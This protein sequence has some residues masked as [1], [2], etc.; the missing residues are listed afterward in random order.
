[1]KKIIKVFFCILTCLIISIPQIYAEESKTKELSGAVEEKKDENVEESLDKEKKEVTEEPAEQSGLETIEKTAE[2]TSNETTELPKTESTSETEEKP[3]EEPEKE[4]SISYTTHIQD[5]GWQNQVK[6]GEMAGTEG[7]SKRL[8][9]IK[10]TLKDLSGVKIKYQTHIQD[11]GWQDWKYDG[12]LAGTE[13]QSKRLEAIRIELEESDKYSIMYRVH[14][15]D[16]G[17][18][19][20]RYDGEKAGTEGQSKRLEAI[21]IKIVEKQTSISV[22]YS[23]HVQDIG[24]QNWKA[25]EKIAGTE[26]QSKRLEAIKIE[27]LTNIK[28]LKLKYRVHIQDIGWQDW[29]DSEEM[30]GTEGQSKRLEAIQ[31]KLEN[32]QDYSIEY[33]VHV[34]DIG[35]QDWVKDGETSGTE[36]QSKRLEAIQIRIISKENDSN[37]QEEPKFERQ[38]GTYGKTG[39]NVADKG[40]SELKYLKYGTGKNVFFATFAIHGYEDKWDKDGY[41]LIEIANNFY[42]KLLEDKD[43][44]LAKKWTIYIFPGVN[45]D[46]LQEGSTNNGPGRTTL[47][48]QAPQNKG[49]DLNRCW[50]IG[51]TYEKFTSD[52]NYNGDIGFQA[53]EAQ[54]LR[55][56]MLKNKSKDGQTILVDLHGWT[57]QLIGDENICSYYEQQFPENNK[58]SVGRYGSGYMIS[59]GRTYLGSQGRPAKTALIEL[60]RDGVKNH[61]SVI[62]KDFSNRYIYATMKMLEKII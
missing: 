61:Q 2:V 46:G 6:D 47:Y 62:D 14:I 43:Y 56:F 42:N 13:G 8:E 36:G 28:N 48:S 34:Q 23:V 5:I 26:G 9:A 20:W 57:Q 4:P 21:Q 19:D 12:T 3:D 40:G 53:Y 17:W 11:I 15:Q 44:D 60:P 39:L 41:E 30:A 59:W 31:I 58:R 22:N 16:I 25:E 49:I 27:L 33:R 24:W 55:D 29:K 54:A 18:Q 38:E 35:W 37:S 52:R 7:Q 51:S 45:Q 32:T 10:I 1:M 50:Q